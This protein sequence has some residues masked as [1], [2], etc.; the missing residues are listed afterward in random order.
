MVII[1]NYS[2]NKLIGKGS[3]SYVYS[4]NEISNKDYEYAIKVI[5]LTK[6]NE[7]LKTKIKL[8]VDILNK[9]KHE[10]IIKLYNSFYHDSILYL[11]LEKCKADLDQYIKENFNIISNTQKIEWIKQLIHGL[12]FLHSNKIIHKDLKPKN[13][14]I[15]E[16]NILKISDFGFARYIESEDNISTICGTPLYMSPELFKNDTIYDYK[17][18]YWSMG[19]IIYFIMTGTIPFNAK[20]ITELMLKLKNITDIKIPSNIANNYDIELINLT[21]SM[22]IASVKHRISYNEIIKHNFIKKNNLNINFI[23]S[24]SLPSPSLHSQSPSL[25]SQSPSLHSPSISANL[26]KKSYTKQDNINFKNKA[27]QNNLV[28]NSSIS[29]N[30]FINSSINLFINS[31]INSPINTSINYSNE[32]FNIFDF[33]SQLNIDDSSQLISKHLDSINGSN[34]NSSELCFSVNETNSNSSELCSSVNETNSN[35]TYNNGLNKSIPI[36]ILTPTSATLKCSKMKELNYFSK[37]DD[38]LN[39]NVNGQDNILSSRMCHSAPTENNSF[40]LDD[41][42][43]YNK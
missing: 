26:D 29:M 34:S 22:L 31:P 39:N 33:S 30:S 32:D 41:Y 42:I 14:L 2:I 5:K 10:N 4:G 18:D 43:K 20:N 23:H 17:S 35:R 19:I 27:F 21:E 6:I 37:Y 13:I 28:L 9:L 11:V 8:E 24:I 25:H 16:D 36:P 7:Q 3:Y 40:L 38:I 1:F 15:T 12:I